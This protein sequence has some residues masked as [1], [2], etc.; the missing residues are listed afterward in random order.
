VEVP[1]GLAPGEYVVS[2]RWD[3]EQTEQVWQNCGD[4]VITA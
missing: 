2:W 4:V 1:A 3:V